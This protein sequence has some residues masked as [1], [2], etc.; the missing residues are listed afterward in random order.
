M[1]HIN[2]TQDFVLLTDLYKDAWI[3]GLELDVVVQG[4]PGSLSYAGT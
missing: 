3:V 1:K 2:N 4:Y